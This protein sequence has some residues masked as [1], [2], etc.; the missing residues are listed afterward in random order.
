MPKKY[1]VLVKYLD[2]HV[3]SSAMTRVEAYKVAEL[4]RQTTT[5]KVC[6]VRELDE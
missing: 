6:I 2:K 5:D 3:I 1:Y 4:L